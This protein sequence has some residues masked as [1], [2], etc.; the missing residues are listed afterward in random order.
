MLQVGFKHKYFSTIFDPLIWNPWFRVWIFKGFDSTREGKFVQN[1]IYRFR[2]LFCYFS[3]F[4]DLYF[5]DFFWNQ[6]T[7][8]SLTFSG[9]WYNVEN[10]TKDGEWKYLRPKRVGWREEKYC[11]DKRASEMC[12]F[13]F[14]ISEI[15]TLYYVWLQSF[16]VFYFYTVLT[17]VLSLSLPSLLQRRNE[18]FR[19]RMKINMET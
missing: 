15:I 12:W 3:F 5:C 13:I 10:K 8:F 11:R 19:L 14:H 2:Y 9:P 17:L 4:S 16:V 7:F 1:K 6:T 18:A